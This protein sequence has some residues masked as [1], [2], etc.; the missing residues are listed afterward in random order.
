M[1]NKRKIQVNIPLFLHIALQFVLGIFILVF[2]VNMM[3]RSLLG[4]APWDTFTYHLHALLNVTLGISAFIIQCTLIIIIMALRKS[5]QYSYIFTSIITISVAFDFWDLIVFRDYYP[6]GLFLR[7]IF[8]LGGITLLSF[9]L[10]LVVLTRFKAT[11]VDELML[12]F[13]DFFKTKNVFMT[14][15]LVEGIG[16]SMGLIIG[17]LAGLGLGIINQG[18]LIVTL[19]LPFLLSLQLRW[20]T[21]IFDIK[22][23]HHIES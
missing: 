2:G 1:R 14:R 19:I 17:L 7:W 18:T 23:K 21:P 4:P 20:M 9:G 16:L 12:L 3:I 22:R 10:G 5:W 11:V 15:M 6:E 13:M 8:Y